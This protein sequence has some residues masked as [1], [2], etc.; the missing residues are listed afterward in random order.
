MTYPDIYFIRTRRAV[1]VELLVL[2]VM[3]SALVVVNYFYLRPDEGFR[4]LPEVL[5]LVFPPIA[6]IKILRH[7]AQQEQ[8]VREPDAN[9]RLLFHLATMMP[10]IGYLPVVVFL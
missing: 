4:Y 2:F 9:M 5:Y 8:T 6:T 10:I 7:L 1:Y 3:T